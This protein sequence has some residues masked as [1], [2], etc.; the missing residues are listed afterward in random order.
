MKKKLTNAG[1]NYKEYPGGSVKVKLLSGGWNLTNKI[2]AESNNS[3]RGFIAIWFDDSMSENI[4]AIESA[5]S[6]CNFRPICLWKE[7]F[8]ETIMEKAL[9]EIKKSRFIIVDLTG[10]RPDVA[11]EAGFAHGLNMQVIYIYDKRRHK[12]LPKCFYAKHYQCHGYNGED[13]LK[14]IVKRLI[15]S[16][17]KK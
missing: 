4:K 7:S 6:D 2:G 5:I 14:E 8:P 3:D 9:G 15:S 16:R 12:D 10:E 17:I 11:F 13:E 1:T